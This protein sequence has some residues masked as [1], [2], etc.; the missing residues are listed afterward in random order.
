MR[1]Y[2]DSESPRIRPRRILL[3]LL[4]VVLSA[5]AMS[6]S[7]CAWLPPADS[8]D[9]TPPPASNAI[10]RP[11]LLDTDH[12]VGS[13]DAPL[14]VVMYE[15][16]QN[17]A[18]GRF[19]RVEFDTIKTE[20]IDTGRVR[21]VFR[22]F[23]SSGN[24]RAKPAARA[25]ECA[26]DQGYFFE[27]RDLIYATVDAD[28]K[29]IL[30]DAKLKDHAETLGLD[31]TAFATCYDESDYKESRI[32]QDINSGTALG[33]TSTPTFLVGSTRVTDATTA[34]KL[35]TY[36]DRALAGL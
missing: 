14:L 32:Q 35:R 24:T 7:T 31:T 19:A 4:V 17:A 25:A 10:R 27:Y 33:V 11:V 28:N 1:P 5:A 21:W 9:D 16:Y 34:A 30:T 12:V 3:S 18:C 20:Y 8:G 6:G 13:S 36:L 22:H 23:P 2:R 15:D 26:H 29:V